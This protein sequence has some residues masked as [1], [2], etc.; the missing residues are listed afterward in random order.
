MKRV[1]KECVGAVDTC[2]ID[3]NIGAVGD[4]ITVAGAFWHSGGIASYT[5][6]GCSSTFSY[7]LGTV[8]STGY[9]SFIA[10]A[11]GRHDRRV[12]LDRQWSQRG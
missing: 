1:T 2:T 9:K 10:Y 4:L 6:S 5:V 8:V 3:I 11:F 12:Y 7:F